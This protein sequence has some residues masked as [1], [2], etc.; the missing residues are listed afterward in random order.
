MIKLNNISHHIGKQKILHD[1]T[2]SLPTA[3]VIALIGPNGAGK[4]TLFSVMAR[5]QPLQAGQVSF[6]VDN[7]ERDIV[8]CQARTLAKTVA[9]LGQDNHVQG[10]LRVHE[11][12]MFGRYPYHQG[13]PTA[14]DQQKVQEILERF[15]L[16]PLAERFLSTLSGGQRQRVLIAMIV[17]Q[18]TPYLLLDE[19]LNNLDMYHAGRLM[20]ELR[21]LSHSQ[22]KTVVIVLHDINQAAQFADTVVTMKAGE[23]MAVGRPA[24][25]ITQETMKDLYNVDV[26]VLNHQGRPVIVDTV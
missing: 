13:Q 10:R 4:S 15:E 17:C 3:Q 6:A 11:L 18:D 26:T 23:V 22:Q 9:M 24:D 16:E 25:V 1:I 21:T 8:S 2:L 7:E 14:E 20:R 5:L 19:P 12:L